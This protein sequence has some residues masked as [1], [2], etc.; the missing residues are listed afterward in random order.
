[1]EN[2]HNSTGEPI[3]VL[4]MNMKE[5]SIDTFD[6]AQWNVI[7]SILKLKPSELEYQITPN[8]NPPIWVI[9]HLTW[10]M[11]AIFNQLCQGRSAL[12]TKSR[13]GFAFNSPKIN[14]EDY[15]LSKMKMIDNFLSIS[16]SSFEYL[17]FLPEEKYDKMPEYNADGNTE[18]VRELLQRIS[19][20]F[21]GHT[22]QI[23][24]VRKELGKGGYFVIGV[25]KKQRDDSRKKW[26][27]WWDE[28]RENY[29]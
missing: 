12:D 29:E 16:K 7:R 9:G 5:Y 28:N 15:P 24:L 25:K 19:L 21:L 14:L 22:G 17:R 23:Y 10:H 4:L 8:L 6:I 27:K 2:F 26:H 20:H 11:D 13:K 1:M 3:F 18:T